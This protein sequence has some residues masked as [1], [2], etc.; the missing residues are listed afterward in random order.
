MYEREY[1]RE[2]ERERERERFIRNNLQDGY[3]CTCNVFVYL[4][5][6]LS[7]LHCDFDETSCPGPHVVYV[8][9]LESEA[10]MRYQRAGP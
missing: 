4:R 9:L 2:T 3:V 6:L 5:A 1:E 7:S 8:L 10:A